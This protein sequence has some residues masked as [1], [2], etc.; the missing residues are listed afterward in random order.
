MRLQDITTPFMLDLKPVAL[1]VCRK[2]LR[3]LILL[4]SH[5]SSQ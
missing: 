3:R 1:P 4:T 5:Y 2:V